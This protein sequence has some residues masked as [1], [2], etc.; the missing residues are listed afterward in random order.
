MKLSLPEFNAMQS[1]PRRLGQ[2]YFELPMFRRIGLDLDH[3]DILEIGCGSGYGADLLHRAFNPKSYV[4]VDVMEEQIHLARK[5][6]PQY[7][8]ILQN[9]EDLSRFANESKDAVIIF[10][11]LHHIPNWR[12]TVDEITRVLRPNGNLFLEEPRGADIKAFDFF[13]RWAHPETD[14]GLQALEAHLT[15]RKLVIQSKQWT[16]LLTMYHAVKRD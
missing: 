8:F 11:V 13:F 14:F 2:K 6:F 16:P 1:M 15:T 9:A 3:K 10:G 12:K 4:G 7:E 5:D